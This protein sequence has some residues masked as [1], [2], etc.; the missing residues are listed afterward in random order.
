[1]SQSEE[2]AKALARLSQKA[3]LRLAR[4]ASIPRLSVKCYLAV[5]SLL[6]EFIGAR[7]K[8]LHASSPRTTAH[9]A[10]C[11]SAEG[12]QGEFSASGFEA[13]VRRVAVENGVNKPRF[14]KGVIAQVQCE[15]ERY[16]LGVMTKAKVV[17]D[18]C[19][20]NVLYPKDVWL[21]CNNGNMIPG[22]QASA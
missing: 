15:A 18:H 16:V 12:W 22:T 2:L 5:R 4:A 7:V 14:R 6:A 1:M 3:I 11:V 17:M 21:V 20:R 9:G 19:K 8:E 13:V 10:E